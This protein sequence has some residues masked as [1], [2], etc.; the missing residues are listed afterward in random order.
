[1]VLTSDNRE[2]RLSRECHRSAVSKDKPLCITAILNVAEV[3]F[4]ANAATHGA[5]MRP[6]QRTMTMPRLMTS[7][8]KHREDGL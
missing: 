3:V 6:F 7:G 5:P 8:E 2:Q 1:V 4:C